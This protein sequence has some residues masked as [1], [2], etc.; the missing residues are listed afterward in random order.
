MGKRERLAAVFQ[1]VLS[2]SGTEDLD[3]LRYR[4]ISGW[5]S[6]GHMQLVAAIETEFDI[7]LDPDE[8]LDLS[9]FAKALELV[10]RH[11]AC[12]RA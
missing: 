6:V 11:N 2:L 7:M 12:S 9:S 4:E 10:D 5:D 1:E 3:T 8:I